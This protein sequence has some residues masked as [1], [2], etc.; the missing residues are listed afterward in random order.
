MLLKYIPAVYILL[1]QTV[2]SRA[3]VPLITG[4]LTFFTPRY[5]NFIGGF[6]EE[7]SITAPMVKLAPGENLCDLDTIQTNITGQV[8][9]TLVILSFGC[10]EEVA[11]ENAIK[12]GAVAVLD[13]VAIPP[14]SYESIHNAGQEF[15]KGDIP[16]LQ[17]GTEFFVTFGFEG[18]SPAF[19]LL[20]GTP[21]NI[22]G[23]GDTIL[24]SKCFEAYKI[25]YIPFSIIALFGAILAYRVAK[26]VKGSA[27][28]R[29]R[30]ALIAYEALFLVFTAVVLFFGLELRQSKNLLSG[31]IISA[32]AKDVLGLLQIIGNVHGSL[33]NA[34]YWNALR[35]GCFLKDSQSAAYWRKEFFFS[36]WQFISIASTAT[37]AVGLIRANDKFHTG[38]I[39]QFKS[40]LKFGVSVDVICGIVLFLSMLHFIL[41]L[42]KVL[43]KSK[44]ES[45]LLR[46]E[47]CMEKLLFLWT[48]LKAIVKGRNLSLG[49]TRPG[50]NNVSEV[51]GKLINLSLHLSKWLMLYYLP[52]GLLQNDPDMCRSFSFFVSYICLKILTSYCKIIGLGGP[53][54]VKDTGTGSFRKYFSSNRIIDTYKDTSQMSPRIQVPVAPRPVSPAEHCVEQNKP[55][56]GYTNN[57]QVAKT[58]SKQDYINLILKPSPGRGIRKTEST[59]SSFKDRDRRVSIISTNSPPNKKKGNRN[60]HSRNRRNKKLPKNNMTSD[61]NIFDYA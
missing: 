11:Y 41:T 35:K 25:T 10:Y 22:E 32:R 38:E 37:L 19:D 16:F 34:I 60:M 57:K 30:I 24:F 13:A 52:F 36:P 9:V 59:Y 56:E 14:G 48:T 7:C 46:E 17:V 61:K 42:R 50:T 47:T 51:H 58:S 1:L 21:I 33:L 18:I 6:D 4:N 53:K 23:C 29:P 20:N 49:L 39:E 8:L 40:L 45:G 44:T 12:L 54:K 15:Q 28:S 5:S 26:R 3:Q 27:S 55:D 2:Y 31:N 43:P